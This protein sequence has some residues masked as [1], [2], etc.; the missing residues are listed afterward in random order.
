[1]GIEE[2]VVA[3]AEADD[4]RA[5]RADVAEQKRQSPKIHTPYQ[6][7]VWDKKTGQLTPG[8]EEYARALAYGDPLDV[9]W[10]RAF[11]GEKY[12]AKVAKNLS[13]HPITTTRVT[14][15]HAQKLRHD[16]AIRQAAIQAAGIDRVW[17][18]EK[19]AETV[20]LGHGDTIVRAD[21]K[22]GDKR[23]IEGKQDLAASTRALEL[24]GRE[25]G[26]FMDQRRP[27]DRPLSD[28]SDEDIDRQLE[29]TRTQYLQINVTVNGHGGNAVSSTLAAFA[30]VI[31][32][33]PQRDQPIAEG[34]GTDP[35]SGEDPAGDQTAA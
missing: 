7:A 30:P 33:L 26:M 28:L 16:T 12:E 24:L 9:A 13:F 3:G 11:P 2:D 17:V 19:L 1:M 14:F 31:D 25:H 10:K 29:Q 6:I 20:L 4:G 23:V 35:A 27:I 8:F 15:L 18:I 21:P 32:H 34:A 5:K 22:T